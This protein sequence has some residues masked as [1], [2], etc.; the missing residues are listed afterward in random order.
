MNNQFSVLPFYGPL[1]KETYLPQNN[2]PQ[3]QHGA[4][5]NIGLKNIIQNV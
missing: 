2:L 3:S 4:Q 1:W 5:R